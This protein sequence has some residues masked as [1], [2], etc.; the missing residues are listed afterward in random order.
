MINLFHNTGP[1]LNKFIEPAWFDIAAKS[2]ASPLIVAMRHVYAIMRE[3]PRLDGLVADIEKVNGTGERAVA[4]RGNGRVKRVVNRP[5]ED[6]PAQY[7]PFKIVYVPSGK[8]WFVYQDGVRTGRCAGLNGVAKMYLKHHGIPDSDAKRR[9]IIKLIEQMLG[10]TERMIGQTGAPAGDEWI[11]PDINKKALKHSKVTS[12]VGVVKG[13]TVHIQIKTENSAGAYDK[14]NVAAPLWVL[15]EIE[16]LAVK[17]GVP[18]F[19]GS[20]N[21][22]APLLVKP[23]G[24]FVGEFKLM[25]LKN[26]SL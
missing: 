7:G 5:T 2:P 19:S 26:Q 14:N 8:P 1:F 6:A 24:I 25:P 22:Y 12:A 11:I 21:Q 16:R 9:E 4:A 3:Q 23:D 10:K 20:G 18:S 15:A 13:K 17:Q